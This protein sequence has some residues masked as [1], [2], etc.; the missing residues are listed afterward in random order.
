MNNVKIILGKHSD[1]HIACPI[2]LKG[3]CVGEGDTYE[4]APK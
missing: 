4:E 2:R 1:E 3:I